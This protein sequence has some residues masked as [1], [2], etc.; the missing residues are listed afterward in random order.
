MTNQILSPAIAARAVAQLGRA[1]A[2]AGRGLCA[3]LLARRTRHA[4]GRLPEDLLVDI[5]L[6]R[7]DIAFVA[8]AL[9]EAALNPPDRLNWETAADDTAWRLQPAVGSL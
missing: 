5:G 6:T 3:A 4:L 2:R 7:G 8:D 1:A 9:A